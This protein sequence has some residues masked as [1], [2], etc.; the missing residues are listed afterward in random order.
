[1]NKREVTDILLP[2]EESMVVWEYS[3]GAYFYSSKD[4]TAP[5]WTFVE[6]DVEKT[7][8]GKTYVVGC[9]VTGVVSNKT[10]KVLGPRFNCPN[11]HQFFLEDCVR[12]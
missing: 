3:F 10:G 1:L 11:F 12:F 8:Y 9:R 6:D 5:S 2:I 4:E 7:F